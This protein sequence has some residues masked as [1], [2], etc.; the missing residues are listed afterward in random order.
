MKQE[1]RPGDLVDGMQ[2]HLKDLC[3]RC[4]CTTQTVWQANQMWMNYHLKAL[5]EE[6]QEERGKINAR[7]II[8]V[9]YQAMNW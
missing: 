7:D 5:D 9:S 4:E 6:Q 2:T 8:H 1:N 3:D